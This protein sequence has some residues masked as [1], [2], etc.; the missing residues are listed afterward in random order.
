MHQIRFRLGFR[1]RPRW[2]SLQRSL[3][4]LAD[5]R[6]RGRGREGLRE[7]EG[8]EKGRKMGREGTGKGW[9]WEKELGGK[10]KMEG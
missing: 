10:G 6:G 3:G 8:T 2:E 5:F 4:P 7:R 9:E 1:R